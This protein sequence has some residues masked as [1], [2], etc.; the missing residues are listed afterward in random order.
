MKW[1]KI[2]GKHARKLILWIGL[3]ATIGVGMALLSRTIADSSYRQ[4]SDEVKSP[5]SVY[6]I[7]GLPYADTVA[8]Q[9][10]NLLGSTEPASATVKF[11]SQDGTA[12]EK[13][14]D[15]AWPAESIRL[16][17]G[18]DDPTDLGRIEYEESAGGGTLMA[19]VNLLFSDSGNDAYLG[20]DF[21]ESTRL[22]QPYAHAIAL[23]TLTKNAAG[24]SSAFVLQN[25]SES[26][27]AA[28]M[29]VSFYDDSGNPMCSEPILDIPAG[30]SR[31]LNLA[32]TACLEDGF[33]GS[34]FVESSEPVAVSSAYNYNNARGLRCSYRGVAAGYWS[35]ALVVPALFKAC[36]LQ[37]SEL[38]VMNAGIGPTHVLVEYSDGLT[39][40]ANLP[41][42]TTQCF[43]QGLEGHAPGWAGAAMVYSSGEDLAAAVNVKA[44]DGSGL[45][46]CWA[47][48]ATPASSF[49]ENMESGLGQSVAFPFLAN[50]YDGWASRIHLYNP[51]ESPVEITPRYVF[52]NSGH[53]VYCAE[54]FTIPAGG[55]VSIPQAQL[56]QVSSQ[57][58]AYFNTTGPLAAVVSAT[59]SKP[60]GTTDRH[61]GY[62]AA[63]LGMSIQFPD[64]CDTMKAIFLPLVRK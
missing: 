47:Y 50:G 26:S 15:S 64:T 42:Y 3:A 25:R 43:L 33:K 28:D 29:V 49:R 37:T 41:P 13:I 8:L 4:A 32:N 18:P 39:A 5:T 2:G 31:W 57:L 48:T 23:M 14:T 62:E 46:G 40:D 20:L 58:M 34:A 54:P 38:C 61:F 45:V 30:G 11:V 1:S 35:D 44:Q 19:G 22:S 6:R 52:A 36:D 51:T 56:P 27:L 9:H 53:F 16:L 60:L 12:L 63:Y 17:T 24:W 10:I 55:V 7:I 59:S 21:I